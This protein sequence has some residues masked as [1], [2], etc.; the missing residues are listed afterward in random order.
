MDP[1]DF[2]AVLQAGLGMLP[3]G[4]RGEF[5]AASSN[6]GSFQIGTLPPTI[7]R[8]WTDLK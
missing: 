2:G 3:Q 5:S 8:G 7:D 1:K 6:D 4:D